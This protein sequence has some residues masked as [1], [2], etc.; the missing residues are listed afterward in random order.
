MVRSVKCFLVGLG[1]VWLSAC[2]PQVTEKPVDLVWPNPPQV[3]RVRYLRSLS[4]ATD[5]NSGRGW[6]DTLIPERTAWALRTPYGVTSDRVGK[7]YVTDTEQGVV[8][9]F[10]PNN[11]KMKSLGSDGPGRLSQPV[12]I[13]VNDRGVVFVS[14]IGRKGVFGFNPEGGLVLALGKNDEFDAPSG[15]AIDSSSTRLYVADARKH[16]V[17]VYN[18]NDGQFLFEFGQAGHKDG[19]FQSPTNLFIRNGE[20][21]VSDSVNSRIQIFDLDGKFLKK[22]GGSRSGPARFARPRGVAVDSEGQIYV[23][24]ALLNN[25]QVFDGEG[26][27]LFLIGA[28]GDGPGKFALPAGVHI[29]EEDRIYIVD[30]FNRR[31]QLFQYL[32]KSQVAKFR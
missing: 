6:L 30:S 15:L 1:F 31:V 3:A 13:A 9:V 20:I 17:R 14:D 16:K 23:A 18:S 4:R 29:D 8:W 26:R 21:Y 11:K 7:I 28:S 24:D 19:E 5:F 22:F 25:L 12:G 10:D 27:L 32:G 2:V